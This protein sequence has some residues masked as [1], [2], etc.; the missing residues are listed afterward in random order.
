MIFSC[1]HHMAL[2]FMGLP[3][4]GW[5]SRLARRRCQ[6]DLP[7]VQRAALDVFQKHEGRCSA[8]RGLVPRWMHSVGLRH[9]T[10]ELLISLCLLAGCAHDTYRAETGPRG[11]GPNGIAGRHQT[12]DRP[13][14][15]RREA[16]SG[17][18][19]MRRHSAAFPRRRWKSPS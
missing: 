13:S 17:S 2:E 7:T 6:Q 18:H 3:S 16:A 4:I 14:R 10:G 11:A 1:F 12:I 15:S 19:R 9:G 8:R 5:R